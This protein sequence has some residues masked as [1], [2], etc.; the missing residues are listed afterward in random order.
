[1]SPVIGTRRVTHAPE[2]ARICLVAEDQAL[3]AMLIQDQLEESGFG[4]AGPFASCSTALAWLKSNTPALA[5]I[6]YMLSDGP[7][8]ELEIEGDK[9][10]VPTAEG[11]MLF[12]S[13]Y[14]ALGSDVHSDLAKMIGADV[15]PGGCI[16]VDDHQRCSIPGLYA[17]GDVVIGLDQISHA[18]G[19]GGV[20]AMTIRND[21]TADTP[22]VR[23]G[24]KVKIV[25]P[26][27]A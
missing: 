27:N 3:I 4:V 1:M 8:R 15:A 11:R 2:S 19:G 14:P 25:E 21:L 20:A 23:D 13:V 5:L 18:M 10:A 17:A 12:D 26:A 22:L 16:V 24:G 6:D 9:L 7:C